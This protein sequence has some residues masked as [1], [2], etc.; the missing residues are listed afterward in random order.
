MSPPHHISFSTTTYYRSTGQH[1]VKALRIILYYRSTCP[2]LAIYLILYYYLLQVHRSTRRQNLQNQ[3]IT[4]GHHVTTSPYILSAST[5]YYK[6]TGQHVV[7][8]PRIIPIPQVPMSPPH[9]ISYSLLLHTTGLQVNTSSKP[10]EAYHYHRSPCP[11]LA[12]YLILYYYLPQV[13]RST[14]RRNSQ[15]HT[16]TTGHHVPTSP[17]ISFSTTTYYRSNNRSTRRQNPQNHTITTRHHVTTSPYILFS[18]NYF[19]NYLI[20]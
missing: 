9:H 15:K 10:S 7:K 5:T 6:S 18:L 13:Y 4:T 8:T 17:Y 14:R 16:I 11:H 19:L 2:H 20:N 3:S 12:I 1:V